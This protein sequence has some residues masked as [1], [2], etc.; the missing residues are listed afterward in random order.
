MSFTNLN[1]CYSFNQVATTGITQLSS[2]DCSEVLIT[3]KSG[4]NVIIYDYNTT[5]A[6][7]TFVLATS[8]GVI[9][10]GITNT[11]QLSVATG[12]GS[13]LIYCRTA[14]Y[15]NLNQR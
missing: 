6:S 8:E 7:R 3:N 4:Q 9:L 12:T 10:R 1:V 5:D 14:Y 13:G 15:S 11:A 2:F